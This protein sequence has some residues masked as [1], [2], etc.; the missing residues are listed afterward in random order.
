MSEMPWI[1]WLDLDTEIEPDGTLTV[2]LVRPKPEHLNHNG[3][4]NAAVVYGVAEVAGAG[5]AVLGFLDLL[6]RTYTVVES[7]E[8]QYTAQAR[9]GLVATARLDTEA[10]LRARADMDNARPHDI[11]IDVDLT[12]PAGVTTGD[13]HFQIALRPRNQVAEHEPAEETRA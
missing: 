4:V 1:R 6:D 9:G 13:A 7:S 5:A 3:A 2:R 11:T 12:D 10:A 8:I